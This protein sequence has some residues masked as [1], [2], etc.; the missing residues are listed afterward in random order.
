MALD[1]IQH[2]TLMDAKPRTG[3]SQTWALD[4]ALSPTDHGDLANHRQS[5]GWGGPRTS[6]ALPW[7]LLGPL[8][9]NWAV[10]YPLLRDSVEP[11]SWG[12]WVPCLHITLQKRIT[13]RPPSLPESHSLPFHD[14]SP[15]F[16][17]C[18][19]CQWLSHSG[20]STDGFQS[21]ANDAGTEVSP[22]PT[23]GRISI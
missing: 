12:A 4:W 23:A 13:N 22:D 3:N 7:A 16:I 2:L 10:Y 20:C 5:S 1:Y 6:E 15:H 8:I 9:Y 19:R 18:S 17:T 14:A 21:S 11:A